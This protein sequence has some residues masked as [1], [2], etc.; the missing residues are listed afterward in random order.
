M[1][2]N[3]EVIDKVQKS[4]ME[5]CHLTIQEIAV[6]V[7]IS[8]GSANTILTEDLGMRRVVEKFLPKLLSPEQQKLHLEVA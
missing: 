8:R 3:A 4:I 5:Y 6:E 7:G 1:N 2:R